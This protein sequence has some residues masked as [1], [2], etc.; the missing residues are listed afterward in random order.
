MKTIDFETTF[1]PIK[2]HLNNRR[3]ADQ[4][5]GKLRCGG[6]GKIRF[7][8]QREALNRGGELGFNGASAY[9]C[10]ACRGWHLTSNG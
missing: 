1:E 7:N 3:K 6:S 2:R 8:S 10:P 9:H 4:S 5:R